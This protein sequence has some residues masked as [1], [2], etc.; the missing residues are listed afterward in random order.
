M[1]AGRPHRQFN[2][3]DSSPFM[4]TGTLKNEL[5]SS[6]M[7]HGSLLASREYGVEW[8]SG[9]LMSMLRTKWP[10]GVGDGW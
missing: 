2:V 10:I 4:A 8:V 5:S 7:N 9:L 6:L 3:S 1:R